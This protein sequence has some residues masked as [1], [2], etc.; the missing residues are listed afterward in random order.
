MERTGRSMAAMLAAVVI[1]GLSAAPV[2]AESP[3]AFAKRMGVIKG[4]SA[5]VNL[6]EDQRLG[7]IAFALLPELLAQRGAAAAAVGEIGRFAAANGFRVTVVTPNQPDNDFVVA[8]LKDAGATRI[9]TR[10]MADMVSIKTSRIFLL[11]EP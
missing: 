7:G 5:V 3:E 4:L 11:P 2:R 6:R 1:A 9:T 8:A 10:V